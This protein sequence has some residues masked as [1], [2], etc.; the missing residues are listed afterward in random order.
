MRNVPVP[1]A[2]NSQS[3]HAK[4]IKTFSNQTTLVFQLHE[5]QSIR[6]Q[7]RTMFIFS[8]V[9]LREH[10][11]R[12]PNNARGQNESECHHNDHRSSHCHAHFLLS[13]ITRDPIQTVIT[14]MFQVHQSIHAQA[15]IAGIFLLDCRSIHAHTT[16][17]SLPRQRATRAP[18]PGQTV[19]NQ[20]LEQKRMPGFYTK[21]VLFSW[22]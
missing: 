4:A 11:D 18:C 9:Q 21:L 22:A 17:V 12:N 14:F 19:L 20:K 8:W 1:S 5:N 10:P 15:L 13:A 3:I 7:V 6:A 16:I 2:C